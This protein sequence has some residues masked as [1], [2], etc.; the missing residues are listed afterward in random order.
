MKIIYH[1]N[2][3]CSTIELDEVEKKELFYQIKIQKMNELLFNAHFYLQNDQHY[4]I[5]K[6]KKS[7]DPNYWDESDDDDKTQLDKSCMEDLEV[8]LT[9]LSSKH[10]GD[11]VCIPCSCIKCHAENMLNI[12]TIKGLGKHQAHYIDLAF[13]YKNNIED[14]LYY[15]KNYQEITDLKKNEHNKQY[16]NRWLKEAS[17]AYEWLLNYKNKHQFNQ[18]QLNF[19]L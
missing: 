11:C 13:N 1:E 19:D 3:L 17:E 7:L 18:M 5:E 16:I 8:Y 9:H 2:P 10:V 6:A 15:L 4:D 12:D 14:A